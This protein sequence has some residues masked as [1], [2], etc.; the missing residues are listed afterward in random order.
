MMT[1]NYTIFSNYQQPNKLYGIIVERSENTSGALI[2]NTP[3]DDTL[4]EKNK[5]TAEFFNT[6]IK[7][8]I[9]KDG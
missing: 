6:Q 8:R 9:K 7:G 4:Q 3:F 1:H 5:E 2:N